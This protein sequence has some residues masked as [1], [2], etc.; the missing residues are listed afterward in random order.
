MKSLQLAKK[1][2][3]HCVRMANSG[4]GSHIGSSLSIADILAVLYANILNANPTIMNTSPKVTPY[5]RLVD[6]LAI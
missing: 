3:L 1:I 5:S 4:K 2:R 6:E